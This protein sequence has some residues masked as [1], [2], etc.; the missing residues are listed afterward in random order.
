MKK[1]VS[2]SCQRLRDL[3]RVE[4]GR[5]GMY[6]L[7]IIICAGERKRERGRR[8]GRNICVG[9]RCSAISRSYYSDWGEVKEWKERGETE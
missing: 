6:V 8:K 2:V 9:L 7:L 4:F 5:V 3:D 1:D